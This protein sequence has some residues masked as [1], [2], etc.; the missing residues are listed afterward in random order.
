MVDFT[1]IEYHN[2]TFM[3]TDSPNDKN[4]DKYI[5]QYER[6]N[7]S[8]IV[9]LCEPYYDSTIIEKKGI[10]IVELPYEDGG[11]PNSDIINKWNQLVS[12]NKVIAI[13][14]LSGL[15]RAP[16]LV[17]LSLIDKGMDIFEAVERVRKH[18]SGA[19]N[20]KQL[21][22]IMDYN[23]KNWSYCILQ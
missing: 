5:E 12:N 4:I 11:I 8:I 19:L 21:G 3:I 1:I 17:C 13:H 23:K 7:V 18:R 14:C 22:F 6:Y 10:R 2:H 15:G 16:L 9:R 20:T